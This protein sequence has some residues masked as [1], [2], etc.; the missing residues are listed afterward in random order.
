MAF[1]VSE[2]NA[3]INRYGLARDNL[4]FVNITAP[5]IG[6]DMP[7]GD[8]SF[9]CQSVALPSLNVSTAEVLPQGY[10]IR[11][12]VP[13]G[14]PL[15]NLNTAFM[16][17][18]EFKTKQF[19]HRWVQSIVNFDNSRGYEREYRNMLPYEVAYKDNYRGTIEVAVYS[20][21]S[22]SIKY[23]YK[24]DN[25]YPVGIGDISE[26]WNNNDSIMTM[27]VQFAYDVYK[28]QGFGSSNI[29]NRYTQP[30]GFGGG[31]VGGL[32]TNLGNFGQALSAI[33]FDNPLQDIV[34]RYTSVA[35]NINSTISGVSG[36]FGG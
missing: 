9:F 15:D 29:A 24:F 10:G 21:Q 7:T 4:F 34:N 20:F 32:V 27:P 8:L 6:A 18:S 13:T 14:L 2:F 33:G 16:V 26:S 36:I 17:D 31:G 12:K 22:E 19:F 23:V 35:S 25:A 30:V 11:E 5:S 1:S 28:V 3:K